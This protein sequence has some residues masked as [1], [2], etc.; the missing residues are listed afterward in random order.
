MLL[1]FVLNTFN[2]SVCIMLGA[3]KL[4]LTLLFIQVKG[5]RKESMKGEAS[6]TLQISKYQCHC[7]SFGN[8]FLVGSRCSTKDKRIWILNKI[9][10]VPQVLFCLCL[11]YFN[12]F[13]LSL[14]FNWSIVVLQWCVSLC[15]IAMWLYIHIDILF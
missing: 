8:A 13:V 9:V 10:F 5:M 14:F 1:S 15:Y 7:K 12:F 3:A 6:V 4:H 2:H 11:F